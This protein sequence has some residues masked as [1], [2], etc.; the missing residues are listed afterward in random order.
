M[1]TQKTPFPAVQSYTLDVSSMY[2]NTT[3]THKQPSCRA[4]DLLGQH[5]RH[6]AAVHQAPPCGAGDHPLSGT[7]RERVAPTNLAELQLQEERVDEA[8]LPLSGHAA[9]AL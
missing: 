7:P 5:T 2:R 6:E 4:L 8:E 9:L 3:E 1:T